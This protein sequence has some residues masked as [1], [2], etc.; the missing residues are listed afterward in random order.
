MTSAEL[1]GDTGMLG[2]VGNGKAVWGLTVLV[3]AVRELWG[4]KPC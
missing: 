4:A 2:A 1:W 3:E